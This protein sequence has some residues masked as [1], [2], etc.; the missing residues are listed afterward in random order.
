LGSQKLLG[1]FLIHAFCLGESKRN[2]KIDSE[3]YIVNE[4]RGAL[5]A[6]R[7]FT[8][9]RR[10]YTIDDLLHDASVAS[11][12]IALIATDSISNFSKFDGDIK[13]L[14]KYYFKEPELNYLNRF[15]KF[16]NGTLYYLKSAHELIK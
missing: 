15:A 3:I 12:L 8:T 2:I 6:F 13:K 7:P 16:P 1:M 14:I 11:Y 9:S 4:V 5:M 10:V